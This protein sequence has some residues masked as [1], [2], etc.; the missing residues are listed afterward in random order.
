MPQYL[1]KVDTHVSLDS[2]DLERLEDVVYDVLTKER[3][4]STATDSEGVGYT[5]VEAVYN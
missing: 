5:D 3:C 1:I 4:A 2:K